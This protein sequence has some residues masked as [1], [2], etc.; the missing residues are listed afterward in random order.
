MFQGVIKNRWAVLY[1]L[2]SLSDSATKTSRDKV[3]GKD[4]KP[5]LSSDHFMLFLLCA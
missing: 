5:C 4:I 3:R 1:L 2:M